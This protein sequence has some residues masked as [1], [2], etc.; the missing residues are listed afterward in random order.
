MPAIPV[1]RDNVRVRPEETPSR[2]SGLS[3]E[4]RARLEARR[5]E[6]NKP[7]TGITVSTADREHSKEGLGDFQRRANRER[8]HERGGDR[9]PRQGE[10]G[11]DGQGGR[12]D[13]DRRQDGRDGK[14]WNEASTPRT[15]RADR[16]FDGGSARIPNRGWDETPRGSRGPG[17]WGKGERTSRGWDQTPRSARESPE[18]DGLDLNAKEW[19]EEQ[20]KL[21]RDWYS[22]DD[23]GAV[24]SILSIKGRSVAG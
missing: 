2:G 22:Y 16:D 13:W 1:R 24:V 6:R 18:Q 8:R 9:E 15:S 11:R 19:E 3:E 23:E 5:R 10:Y 20:V 17:G 7:S 12:N 14:P 4:A 21:D